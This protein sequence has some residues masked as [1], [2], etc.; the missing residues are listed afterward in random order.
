MKAKLGDKVECEGFLKKTGLCIY[1]ER[2]SRKSEC[3]ETN[4]PQYPSFGLEAGDLVEIK[5]FEPKKF[6]GF[7]CGKRH[8]A[9]HICYEINYVDYHQIPY[10]SKENYVDCYEVCVENKN[11]SWGK[12]L[13]PID[14]IELVDRTEE[15]KWVGILY[16]GYADGQPVYDI[17]E[18]SNCKEEYYTDDV[19]QLPNY[20]PNCGRKMIKEN[21]D[22]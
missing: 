17:F 8:V 5:R 15:A 14:K 6:T 7:V 21:K 22:E 10:I 16:D 18:C 12:R 13:V 20:C 2:D 3:I 4:D 19:K 9:T 11:K 1:I